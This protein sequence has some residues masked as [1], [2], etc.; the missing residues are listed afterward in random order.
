[1]PAADESVGGDGARSVCLGV[2]CTQVHA[3]TPGC[4]AGTPAS[5]A[6]VSLTPTLL[7]D[8]A[9]HECAR[10]PLLPYLSSLAACGEAHASV[11]ARALGAWLDGAYGGAL[12]IYVSAPLATG[13]RRRATARKPSAVHWAVVLDRLVVEEVVCCAPSGAA[14]AAGASSGSSTSPTA[15]TPDSSVASATATILPPNAHAVAR[16]WTPT[17]NMWSLA[18]LYQNLPSPP[19]PPRLEDVP[20]V[21]LDGLDQLQCTLYSY[22]RSS[23][24]KMLQRELQPT[25]YCDPYYIAKAA[26]VAREEAGDAGHCGAE[27]HAA[28]APGGRHNRS[29]DR[30]CT[31]CAT[32]AS[33]PG[34]QAGCT[35]AVRTY[36][37]DPVR[38]EFHDPRDIPSYPD[39]K[40]GILCDEMGVGKTIIC[41]A[42]IL[43]TL[44]HVSQPDQEPMAS[45]VTSDLALSFSDAEYEG[46][47]PAAA[48]ASERIVTAAFGAPSPGE[49]L[50][51]AQR[52][53][54]SA[55][56]PQTEAQSDPP[57]GR[58]TP[59][60]GTQQRPPP[61]AHI[62]AHRLRTTASPG[63]DEVALLPPPLQTLLGAQSAPFFHLW[64]PAP[65]RMSRVSQARRALRVY[66]TSATLV[67]VPL[68]LLVQWTEEIH[69]H[70][71]PDALRVLA[72]PDMQTVLPDACALA[73]DYDVLLMSHTRF[74]KE[75]GDDQQGLR[76]DLDASP[77]LQ[78]HWKRV[79]IDEGNVLAGDSLV[80]RL[81]SHLRVERRWIVTGTPTHGLRKNIDRLRLLLV[82][83]LR[84]A[85]FCG[86]TAS[87]ASAARAS[88]LPSGKERDWSA[89]MASGHD[90]ALGEWPAKRRLFDVL[91]RVMVRNRAEDVE[92]ECPLPPLRRRTVQ[93]AFSQRERATYNVLQ[94]LIVLNAALSEETDRDYVFHAS[95]RKALAAVMEN[96]ALACFHFAGEGLCEQATQARDTI[97]TQLSRPHG[98]QPQY[99][100][101]A[102]DALAALDA[103]LADPA[104]RARVE[105]GDVLYRVVHE[106]V[107]VL[108][109]WGGGRCT[110][111]D[112]GRRGSRP[113]AGRTLSAD[114]L[115][116]LRHAAVRALGDT[117]CDA[118][119]FCDELITDG[120]RYA[121]RDADRALSDGARTY[122]GVVPLPESPRRG[123]GKRPAHRR[124][125]GGPLAQ[126]FAVR[127]VALPPGFRDMH[128]SGSSSTKL[129][130]ILAEIL[131]AAPTEKVLVFSNLDNV[132]YELANALEVA[133][134]PILFY[135]SGMAQA[136]RNQY[137]SVFAHDAAVRCLLMTTS[138]GGR[139]LDLHCAS[140]VILAEPIWQLDVESQVIKRAWRMGQTRPVTVST[141]VM[142]DSFEEHLASRTQARLAERSA[143]AVPEQPRSVADDV[144]MRDYVAHPRFVSAG[145]AADGRRAAADADAKW[146][147]PLLQ[148][149]HPWIVRAGG[150]PEGEG[151][152]GSEAA[153][154]GWSVDV[155]RGG[156]ENAE[157]VGT[158]RDD[159]LSSV[160]RR[161]RG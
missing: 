85:P 35:H 92:R 4:R 45:A 110:P 34:A 150:G 140:R 22:Q 64:P 106:R 90:A 56:R 104:W 63:V 89:L 18:E 74:G 160:K 116:A 99:H 122:A 145:R 53:A 32:C 144:A 28:R 141:Y 14:G 152:L 139:G 39:V 24:A 121:R 117:R 119:D 25:Q 83:F 127:D 153:T 70:C 132:L 114:E 44:P 33:P 29:G 158:V 115:L 72:V 142:A 2:A 102:Q 51:R 27:T 135:V 43:A 20:Y 65:A 137:A 123:A 3:R 30:P 111:A 50:G 88:G 107:D 8:L 131:A 61:L 60:R 161:R 129:N 12:R 143:A 87:M 100:D 84:M 71:R 156:D 9:A 149:T 154:G 73:Q 5:D 55:G 130:A 23:L 148:P 101:S 36:V 15:P 128:V 124:R 159:G 95:N 155:V 147:L 16:F 79:I 58:P 108:D 86:P 42:L 54:Q 82:R 78:V 98:I 157:S 94:A 138:V 37:F 57:G 136:I 10:E 75:A 93:L 47:D 80:V 26:Y 96:L 151:P 68:T 118:D 62:A 81:C 67:I 120:L 59:L 21:S 48:I 125:R 66:L 133:H 97:R 19:P 46:H 113:P 17:F 69:K 112:T 11:A 7:A 134:V 105:A 91:S 13:P 76:A 146:C 109:A 103:A 41:L 126:R 77:L 40:G 6:R 1:M 49:R 52:G 31:L 38:Y